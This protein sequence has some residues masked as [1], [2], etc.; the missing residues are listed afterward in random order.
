MIRGMEHLSCEDWL[1]ELGLF[2]PSSFSSGEEKAPGRL[3]STLQ[4]NKGGLE[5]RASL[6]GCAVIG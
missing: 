3:N 5:E 6:S 1:R 4:V 2:T